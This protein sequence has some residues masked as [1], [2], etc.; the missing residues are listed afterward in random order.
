MSILCV[1]RFKLRVEK[2]VGLKELRPT[3]GLNMTGVFHQSAFHPL[4]KSEKI[5][6]QTSPFIK[7]KFGVEFP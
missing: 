2:S 6:P 7:W 3:H 5:Q 1:Y 4:A